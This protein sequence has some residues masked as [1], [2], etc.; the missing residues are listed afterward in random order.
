MQ[1]TCLVGMDTQELTELTVGNKRFLVHQALY[2]DLA[3]LITAASAAGFTMYIASGYRSFDR[4][5]AIWNSKMSGE[6]PILDSQ[7]QPIES[8]LLS[9]SEKV[10]AI[11]RW[12]ALPGASR[13]HWGTDFDVYAGNL[14]PE[15]MPLALEPW[16]YLDGHQAPFYRWLQQYAE[17]FGFFFPYQRDLGGVAFE[18]WHISHKHTAE[19]C[20]QQLTPELLHSV[21]ERSE[22]LGREAILSEL[23]T[24]YNQ[25][26]TNICR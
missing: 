6:Q 12:S 18:P 21:I 23:N 4:Q 7:S 22:I 1:N 10:S 24:I 19:Y 13:H 26:V 16:E 17:P 15:G 8:H 2:D 20:L 3:N 25:Y 5:L 9:D 14:L 11:L